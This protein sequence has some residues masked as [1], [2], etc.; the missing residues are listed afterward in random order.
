MAIET[1]DDTYGMSMA[2]DGDSHSVPVEV[3]ESQKL[4]TLRQENGVGDYA[5]VIQLTTGQAYDML[6]ALSVMLSADLDLI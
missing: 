6:T 4:I 3:F 2:I 5:D 1:H